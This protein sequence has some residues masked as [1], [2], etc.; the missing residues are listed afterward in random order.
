MLFGHAKN[1]TPL[2][3]SGS[4]RAVCYMPGNAMALQFWKVGLVVEHVS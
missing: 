1:S 2:E 3:T 4:E